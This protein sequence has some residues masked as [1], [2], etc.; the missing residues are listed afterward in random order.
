[1]E[2]DRDWRRHAASSQQTNTSHSSSF[3][4]NVP[5]RAEVERLEAIGSNVQTFGNEQD[6]Q[7]NISSNSQVASSTSSGP[8][9]PEK[10]FLR[11]ILHLEKQHD[12]SLWDQAVIE[13][14]RT[15]SM[16]QPSTKSILWETTTLRVYG[17]SLLVPRRYYGI[18]QWTFDEL[19]YVNL[20]PAD[21][22]TLASTFHTFILTDVPIL[23]LAQKNE[24][25]RFITLLDALYEARCKLLIRATAGPDD[26]FFPELEQLSESAGAHVA[27]DSDGVYSETFSDI[28]QDQT[29]PFRPNIS[30]Y[31][32]SAS[33]PS[34]DSYPL[35]TFSS[36]SKSTTRSARSILADEDSDFG[37]VYGAE[38]SPPGR[39]SPW[40][41]LRN[42]QSDPGNEIRPQRGPDFG[43]SE[44]FIGDNERF[45]Y[46]RARSRLWEMCGSKWWARDDKGW[47]RPVEKL[48]RR[49]EGDA[50]EPGNTNR[51]VR[52]I[53][54]NE[55]VPPKKEIAKTEDTSPFRTSQDPPPKI[56]GWIHAWGMTRWGKKAGIWGKGPEGL[57]ER[58]RRR[59]NE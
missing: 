37:P 7:R 57:D 6:L 38:R 51:D 44:T 14:L 54:Q 10:Y 16:T 46:K 39:Y 55:W 31:S 12:E 27:S 15:E 49:W 20:G 53:H 9:L 25:R 5:Q 36:L 17:R 11:P 23:N 43:R 32:S 48:S 1:M 30:S 35:P 4:H 22:I 3:D 40:G 41:G 59:G 34:Y 2:G 50:K 29:S 28:Y 52:A 18:T 42:G 13:I 47:W 21:Y 24:A 58:N 26:T 56:W 33:S 8:A 19:C 45:A